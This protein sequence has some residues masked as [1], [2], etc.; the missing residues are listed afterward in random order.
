MGVHVSVGELLGDRNDGLPFIYV[1]NSRE[2]AEP[3][4]AMPVPVASY[5]LLAITAAINETIPEDNEVLKERLSLIFNL[6]TEV[7]E[8]IIGEDEED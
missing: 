7:A 1:A 2:P 6:A 8:M 3:L 4:I 5:A